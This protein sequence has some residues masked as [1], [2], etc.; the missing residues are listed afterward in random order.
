M[1]K[2]KCQEYGCRA[3]FDTYEELL[4]HWA[5]AHDR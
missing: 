5:Y 4:M 3:R 2:F 1:K